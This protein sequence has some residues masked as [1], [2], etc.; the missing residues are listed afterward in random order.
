MLIEMVADIVCPWCYVGWRRFQSALAQRPGITPQIAWRAFQL[1]PDMPAIGM[2]RTVY[3]IQKFGP[4]VASMRLMDNVVTA[5]VSIGIG[6]RFDRIERMPNSLDA[7]RMIGFAARRGRQ[8]EMIERLFSDYF[9]AG[10]DIG[11][12]A[13]LLEAARDIGFDPG[14][15]AR[16]LTSHDGADAALAEDRAARRLGIGGVPCF[17]VGGRYAL[18]GAQEPEFFLPLFDLAKSELHAGAAVA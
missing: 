2:S 8:A 4:G 15:A 9:I 6:F 1:N 7:H 11:S 16:H 14:E 12:R 3:M 10:R 18:S 13:V 5:G 17:V